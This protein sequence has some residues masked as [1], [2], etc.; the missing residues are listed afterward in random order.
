MDLLLDLWNF[1]IVHFTNIILSENFNLGLEEVSNRIE[2]YVKLD[3]IV[4]KF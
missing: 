2:V 3:Y 1:L 4:I